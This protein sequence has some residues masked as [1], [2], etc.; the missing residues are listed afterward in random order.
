METDD[1]PELAGMRVQSRIFLG[2]AAFLAVAAAAYGV[3]SSEES[4]TTMLFL[5]GGMAVI[6]GGYLAVQARAATDSGDP[7]RPGGGGAGDPAVEGEAYLPHASI[8]PFGMGMGLVVM[9]NGLALGLWA[10]IPG[11][12]LSAS[13]LWGY[14]RQSRRRD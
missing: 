14:A 1:D 4:G 8:W 7:D 11:A 13:C 3:T 12:L 10:L 2:I 9:A 6:V 5:A